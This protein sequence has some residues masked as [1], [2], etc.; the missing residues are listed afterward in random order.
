MNYLKFNRH[1]LFTMDDMKL[2]R[3][4][5]AFFFANR[6]KIDCEYFTACNELSALYDGVIYDD[7]KWKIVNAVRATDD[8]YFLYG[9]WLGLMKRI[10][11]VAN[12]PLEYNE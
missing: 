5:D 12:Q 8:G 1:E 11:E 2:V 10:Y 9:E 6:D 4:L 3:N 7:L